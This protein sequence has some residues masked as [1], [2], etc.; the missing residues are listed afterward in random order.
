MK[1]KLTYDQRGIVFLVLF[2]LIVMIGI[3]FIGWRV[4]R[5]RGGNSGAAPKI[6]NQIV[7]P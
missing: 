4:Y 3:G 1:R 5:A 6:I 7:Q 2:F